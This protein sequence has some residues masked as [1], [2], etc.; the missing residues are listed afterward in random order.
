[1]SRRRYNTQGGQVSGPTSA[2]TSFLREH[3]ITA[4]RN[5][6]ARNS[7][8]VDPNAPPDAST[9]TAPAASTSDASAPVP[10]DVVEEE[11][12]KE[13]EEKEEE[14]EEEAPVKSKKRKA[15]GAGRAKASKKKKKEEE[16]EDDDA[17]FVPKPARYADRTPGSFSMCGECGK[18]FTVTKYTISDPSGA[19]LCPQCGAESKASAKVGAS[20]PLLKPKARKK[21]KIGKRGEEREER[22]VRSLQEC[23]IKIV[24]D[25]INNVDM[26]GNIGSVNMDNICKIV[27]KHRRMTHDVLKL[28]LDPQ[29]KTLSIYDCTSLPP[30]SLSLIPAFSPHLRSLTLNMCGQLNDDTL[31]L[32]INKLPQ[33]VHLNLYGAHLITEPCWK[34]FFTAK[35][36]DLQTF[37]LRGSA[38][39]GI[40]SVKALCSLCPNVSTVCLSELTKMDDDC[41]FELEA[42]QSLVSLDLSK[43]G[44]YQTGYDGGI[45]TEAVVSLLQS[46]G[47]GLEHLNLGYNQHLTDEVL[48]AIGSNCGSLRFLDL[49]H[50]VEL[51]DEGFTA[52]FENWESNKGLVELDVSRC[53][54][55][56][57]AAF[58]ALIKHSGATLTR[59]NLNSLDDLKEEDLNRIVGGSETEAQGGCGFIEFL[60]LSFVRSTDD[61]LLKA[62]LENLKNLKLVKVYGCNRVTDLCPRK[63]GVRVKGQEMSREIEVF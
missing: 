20:T 1:M 56:G 22:R 9:S 31:R 60:D 38:R 5:P 12:E 50:V 37:M 63:R 26:L 52:L 47:G 57:S 59:L 32:F 23:C 41:V 21:A 13:E 51:T 10:M 61:Y 42:L 7:R 58:A 45:S 15:A 53:I 36:E 44:R 11:E 39:F 8:A 49:N 55:F 28:F 2:L 18:K 3:G 16:S 40:E 4:P 46:I 30:D 25:N 14:E 6:Y 35:G 24:A 54:S 33:L 62:L 48:A 17:E 43:S 27:C 29:H 34:E 19:L